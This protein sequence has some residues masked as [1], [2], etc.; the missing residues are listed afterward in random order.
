MEKLEQ[1]KVSIRAK[2]EHP[3]PVVKNLFLHLHRNMRDER[4][5]NG[6]TIELVVDVYN[7]FRL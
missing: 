4:C 6:L 1:A 2:A 7:S 5:S 3:F